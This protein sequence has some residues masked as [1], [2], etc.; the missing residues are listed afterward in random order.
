MTP[1]PEIT[2]DIILSGRQVA[3][4]KPVAYYDKHM[5]CIR[6]ELRDCSITEERINSVLTVLHDNYPGPGQDDRAGLMLKGMKHFFSTWGMEMD[7]IVLV[8]TILNQLLEKLPHDQEN[9]RPIQKIAAEIELTVDFGAKEE[10]QASCSVPK[11]GGV[12]WF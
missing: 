11:R 3:P 5:D 2:L 7:G 4:F 8:T 6:I 10:E 12:D 9:I 1:K